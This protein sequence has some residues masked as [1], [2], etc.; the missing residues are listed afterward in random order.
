MLDIKIVLLKLAFT[1]VRTAA[2]NSCNFKQLMHSNIV[3]GHLELGC[4]CGKTKQDHNLAAD[5]I[6]GEHFEFGELGIHCG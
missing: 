2:T 6:V 4:H 1:V 5:A 3:G